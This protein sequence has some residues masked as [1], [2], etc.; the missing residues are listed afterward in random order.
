MAQIHLPCVNG[1]DLS[2]TSLFVLRVSLLKIVKIKISVYVCNG[3]CMKV[4]DMNSIFI[5]VGS[6]TSLLSARISGFVRLKG[7]VKGTGEG[8]A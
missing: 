3:E 1:Q 6:R 5:F 7:V 4:K 8:L 2:N